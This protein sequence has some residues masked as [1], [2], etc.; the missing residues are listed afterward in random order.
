MLTV[1]LLE[2]KRSS[3]SKLF[4]NPALGKK[5]SEKAA[6]DFMPRW[7]KQCGGKFVLHGAVPGPNAIPLDG[8]DYL[9][10]TDH[11]GIVQAQVDALRKANK[12]VVQSGVF[13]LNQH[14]TRSTASSHPKTAPEP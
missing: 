1:Q 5:L 7:N 12:F 13:H 14:P 3:V 6:R 8:N 10:I 9:C 4:T 2:Q 11:P